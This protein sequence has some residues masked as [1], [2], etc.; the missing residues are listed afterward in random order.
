MGTGDVLTI[1]GIGIGVLGGAWSIVSSLLT[2][3]R[4]RI[5]D[6][7]ASIEGRL[8]QH[9]V[10]VEK[11]F[12]K[13]IAAFES[14]NNKAHDAIWHKVDMQ[15]IDHDK[16]GIEVARM[17]VHLEKLPTSAD[18]QKGFSDFEAKFERRFDALSKQI[19]QLTTTLLGK[20]ES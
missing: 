20:R 11:D 12:E 19:Q 2:K 6:D 7:I 16:L 3:D 10:D 14:G 15:R 5:D 13:L 17:G 9:I 1:V 8:D 4:A 18:Y